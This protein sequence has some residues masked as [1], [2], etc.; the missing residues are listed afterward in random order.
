MQIKEKIAILPTS[1]GVY[2]FLDGEGR[3]IYVG[4]AVNLRRRVGSY[5]LNL[6]SH[7]TKVRALVKHIKDMEYTVVGSEQDA[8]LLENNL[9]K[10]Y[11]PQYNILLKDSKTYPWIL[12]TSEPFPRILST[13]R[14]VRGAGEYFGPY[15]NV[16]MQKAL[17]ALLREL[18]PLRTCRLDLS[19]DKI[20][21][22]RYSVCLE[23]H[24]GN[25]HGCCT[26][27]ESREQYDSYIA[28]CRK[29]LKGN[30]VSVRE[31]LTEEMMQASAQLRFEEAERYRRSLILL[32][33]YSSHSVVV[34]TTLS[35]VDVVNMHIDGD[36]A[37]C[38]RM[39]VQQGSIVGSY[40][41]EL[42]RSL[43]ETPGELLA[44]A[45]SN[46]D[47]LSKNIVVPFLPE[48]PLPE[49]KEFTIPQRGDMVR[50]LELSLNNCKQQMVEKMKYLK[51][52]DPQQ[53]AD[54]IMEKMKEELLLPA[55]PRHIECFDNSNLQGTSPVA[56]CVVFRDGVPSRKEYR[57]FNIKTVVG[58]NDFASMHEIVE[59]RYRRLLDEGQKLPDLI[60]IDGGKGQL[61]FA[62]STLKE[63]GIDIPVVGLAERLEE[64]FRPGISD[65]MYL[66]KRGDTLRVLMHIRDEAHRFGI[67]F[68]RKKRSEKFLR[69][70]LESISGFGPVSVTK[71]LKKYRTEKRM[72]KAPK[73]ELVALIGK[74]RTEKLLEY[75]SE[76]S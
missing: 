22:G 59:R 75:L 61:S 5:F 66:D 70:N 10:Q 26:G 32:E 52:T 28:S 69:S 12:L 38:N 73:E 36:I 37:Y 4:K 6:E 71:L 53:H 68:H 3:I 50:L 64:V 48:A 29:I 20:A 45:L 42:R 16:G 7:T 9:I 56:A 27:K 57:H 33:N 76:K 46:L 21:G 40:S 72:V 47:D 44:F 43:D 18:F 49:G 54:R 55:E 13:R 62:H 35:N 2:R 67:T 30:L 63:L 15:S 74:D 39:H 23:Y 19:D 65:P 1:P 51:K 60:V 14:V 24:M 11:K 17:L 25:C 58:A 41:F 34:S 31:H 8:L